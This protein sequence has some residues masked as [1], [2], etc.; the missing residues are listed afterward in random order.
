MVKVPT[1]VLVLS[2]IY[3]ISGI[4]IILLGVLG[5]ICRTS[6]AL[7]C[8]LIAVGLLTL[9]IAYGLYR[10]YKWAWVIAMVNVTLSALS[11]VIHY[12][13]YGSMDYLTLIIDAIV[14]VALIYSADY[15]GVKIPFLPTP[16]P[17]ATTATVKA[18]EE[19]K[20]FRRI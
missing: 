17:K 19:M 18:M 13:R 2:G 12:F 8:I 20:F 6:T 9:G 10:G 16:K 3:A 1:K 7:S 15:Y 14:A 4:T 11:V 5:V